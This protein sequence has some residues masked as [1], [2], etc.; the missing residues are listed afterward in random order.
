MFQ[1]TN[2]IGLIVVLLGMGAANWEVTASEIPARSFTATVGEGVRDQFFDQLLKFSDENRFAIRIALTRPGNER[3][4]VKM[5]REDIKVIGENTF[6][7]SEFIFSLY[8]NCYKPVMTIAFDQ[9]VNGLK[10]IV[11][12]VPGITFSETRYGDAIAREAE[13]QRPIRGVTVTIGE[14]V[15]DQY[16]DQLG[17]F[18]DTHGF[19]IRIERVHPRY[20]SFTIAMYRED[21]K[22]YGGNTTLESTEFDLWFYETCDAPVPAAVLDQLI[23]GLRRTV[24][25][26]E[27]ATFSETR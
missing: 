21:V 5:W 6:D 7:T 24:G 20:E 16:F 1:R 17:A 15:R 14:A 9:L 2:L 22:A 10:R 12:R 4:I 27:G 23:D 13:N 26:I 19:A 11:G 18:A 3:F 25:Q 8:R